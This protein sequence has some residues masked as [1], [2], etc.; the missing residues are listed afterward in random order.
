M[1][2]SCLI[3][4]VGCLL[5]T[6]QL[7]AEPP[8]CPQASLVMLLE[9]AVASGA[10]CP[11]TQ[12]NLA[13][14]AGEQTGKWLLAVAKPPQPRVLPQA[15]PETKD[16]VNGAALI[17]TRMQIRRRTGDGP[18]QMISRPQ[19]MSRS[20]GD[21][22]VEIA[23]ESGRVLRVQLQPQVVQAASGKAPATFLAKM[24]IEE[25][26]ADGSTH[27]LAR[28]HLIATQ[29][30]EAG[31]EVAQPQGGV[32]SV[33]VRMNEVP[34]AVGPE[35]ATAADPVIP[36]AVAT[37]D[38]E[39]KPLPPAPQP[40]L[41]LPSSRLAA[42]EAMLMAKMVIEEHDND[43]ESTIISKPQIVAL[44]GRDATIELGPAEGARL[45]VNL[46]MSRIRPSA[47]DRTL[48]LQAKIR[49]ER[50]EQDGSSK[51][52]AE[53]TLVTTP[54]RPATIIVQQSKDKRMAVRVTMQE[55]RKQPVAQVY[56][57]PIPMAPMRRPTDLAST[58]GTASHTS[59]TRPSSIS[60]YI[61]TDTRTDSLTPWITTNA[62]AP[63]GAPPLAPQPNA[64]GT[65]RDRS[66]LRAIDDNRS[67]TQKSLYE[68]HYQAKLEKMLGHIPGLKVA[69]EVQLVG[70]AAAPIIDDVRVAITFPDD[71]IEKLWEAQRIDETPPTSDA[72]VALMVQE[73]KIIAELAAA[74]LPA[75]SAESAVAI[76]AYTS[77]ETEQRHVQY[78]FTPVV[79]TPAP[80]PFTFEPWMLGVIAITLLCATI[81]A[82][83]LFR[84]APAPTAP[85]TPAGESHRRPP[86]RRAA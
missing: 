8:T 69:V 4:V 64:I 25:V 72:L 67:L 13:K 7:R 49:I 52:L 20:G 48:Q 46:N 76:H 62:N 83:V 57:H 55:I 58:N 50:F 78:A 11:W 29:N 66:A 71:Y 45:K 39:R 6:S 9:D 26:A 53:P 61:R 42:N 35:R 31:I 77:V 27:I 18:W 23:Q 56:S 40:P 12:P 2:R 86:R 22:R 63:L 81:G 32:L 36:K 79:A 21:A 59:V 51:V 65:F 34:P 14:T 3:A 15:I 17:L 84:R 85:E 28:P 68:E 60:E 1:K 19:L 70:A 44:E 16:P 73:K 80:Q 54:N 47:V 5:A 37:T 75:S 38:L 82:L 41:A 24:H 74:I 33:Q 10:C 30:R 43:G